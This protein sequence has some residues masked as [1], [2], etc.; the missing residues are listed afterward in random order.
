MSTLSLA[1]G[2]PTLVDKVLSR[3]IA[4]DVALV[5]AGTALT[6]G[7]A[8]LV[9]PIWPVPVTGQTFAVL[10]VGIALGP[11]RG[12]LSMALYAVLGIVG[13]PVFA[14]GHSGS[15]LGSTSGGFV[16]GFVFAAMLV[17]WLAQRNWDH[18]IVGT[19]VAF[20]AGTAVMYAFGLPWLYAV[21][22]TFPP[23]TM[24]QFFGTTNLLQATFTGG[25]VPFL[26]SDLIKAVLAAALLPI[27]W[28]L[29]SRAD[30]RTAK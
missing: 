27:S 21:L 14:A 25:V 29:V 17:G 23:A 12:A 20:V 2:R 28:K 11:L 9:I 10:L 22:S 30:S 18:K 3:S 24:T 19:F 4:T 6:A 8:Q 15:L 5:A 1:L 7:A 13:L 16:I 26:F